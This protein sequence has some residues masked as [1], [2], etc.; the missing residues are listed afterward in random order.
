MAEAD[1]RAQVSTVISCSD[2]TPTR[3][4]LV[5]ARVSR[6]LAG[7]LYDRGEFRGFRTRLDWTKRDHAVLTAAW[8]EGDGKDA[9]LGSTLPEVIGA[10]PWE[11]D[12][13]ADFQHSAHVNIQEALAMKR[14]LIQSMSE[15]VVP[16]RLA[17]GS[18]SWVTIGAWGKGRSSSI[19]LN[20]VIRSCVGPRVLGMRWLTNFYVPTSANPADDPSRGAVLRAVDESAAEKLGPLLYPQRTPHGHLTDGPGTQE[21]LFL[22]VCQGTGGLSEAM[23]DEGFGVERGIDAYDADGVYVVSQ[24]LRKRC[25]RQKLLSLITAGVYF[26]VHFAVPCSTWTILKRC[27]GGTRSKEQPGGRMPTAEE[28]QAN[29]VATF[30]LRCCELLRKGGTTLALKIRSL[31]TFGTFCVN[32][33]CRSWG[34]SLTSISASTALRS[35]RKVSQKP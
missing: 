34:V 32:G 31:R 14:R 9:V 5:S 3:G 25:V 29:S 11:V 10:V 30:V 21:G 35:L 19:Q 16:L 1:L 2:A 13:E 26:Y 7:T 27:G 20:G 28:K 15:G 6:A 33:G 12:W 23:F 18:D 17:N 24:D 8:E 22:E 4:G